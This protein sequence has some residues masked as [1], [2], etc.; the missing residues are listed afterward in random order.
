MHIESSGQFKFYCFFEWWRLEWVSARS[1]AR[2]VLRGLI[3]GCVRRE[4]L[5]RGL[6]R[7]G[8]V[9]KT[10]YTNTSKE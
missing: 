4:L 3:A 2:R 10:A 8:A 6:S 7:K 9:W 1:Q 5:V